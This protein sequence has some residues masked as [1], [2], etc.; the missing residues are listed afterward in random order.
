MW[1]RVCKRKPKE[2]SN[3]FNSETV[4]KLRTFIEWWHK[5]SGKWQVINLK[6]CA[7]MKPLSKTVLLTLRL[8]DTLLFYILLRKE[9]MLLKKLWYY[10][11]PLLRIF[12]YL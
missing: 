3:T 11:L 8:V 1:S 5:I 6:N 2:N 4:T 7:V 9:K 12:F 10:I